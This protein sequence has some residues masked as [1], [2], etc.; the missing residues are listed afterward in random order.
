[1]AKYL[2]E[3]GVQAFWNKVKTELSYKAAESDVTALQTTVAGK[4]D[5]ATTLAGYG[6]TDAYK[7]TEVDTKL[8]TKADSSTVSALS[9]NLTNNYYNKTTV[10]SKISAALSSVFTFK[11]IKNSLAELKEYIDGTDYVPAVGDVWH[12]V[13]GG[14]LSIFDNVSEGS[15]TVSR[16][17]GDHSEIVFVQAENA[18]DD[19]QI[20]ED[21]SWEPLGEIVDLSAYLTSA[22]A[23]STYEKLANKTQDISGNSTNTTK[24]P[25]AKAVYDHVNDTVKLTGIKANGTAVTPTDKA[26]NIATGS[27]DGTISVGG[28]DVSVKGL[29][30]AAYMSKDTGTTLGTGTNTV[31]TS[32]LVKDY[33]DTATAG[34]DSAFFNTYKQTNYAGTTSTIKTASGSDRTFTIESITSSELAAILNA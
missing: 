26:V 23:A 17:I 9:T 34:V 28:T 21:G 3:S 31:P 10:D 4:A 5:K 29:G 18:T 33:V 1:M 7:K 22:T 6:I 12:I 30:T 27:G 20:S 25:S 15:A 11:G 13:T 14:D 16:L 32:K 2:D 8:G 19:E 24:Y